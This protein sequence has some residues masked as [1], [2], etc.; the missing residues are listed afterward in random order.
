[1]GLFWTHFVEK[2]ISVN[3]IRIKNSSQMSMIEMI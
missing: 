2:C 1:M 3:K